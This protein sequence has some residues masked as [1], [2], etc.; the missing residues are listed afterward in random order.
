LELGSEFRLHLATAF[1]LTAAAPTKV[2][3]R[4][5][6]AINHTA[7]TM[8]S[9]AQQSTFCTT[10][11]PTCFCMPSRGPVPGNALSGLKLE[12]AFGDWH[13]GVCAASHAIGTYILRFTKLQI[14]SCTS[15]PQQRAFGL[16]THH[17]HHLSL[18]GLACGTGG[19][20]RHPIGFSR[21]ALRL[22]KLGYWEFTWRK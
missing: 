15:L 14:L 21:L 20:Q 10:A 9:A 3:M 19:S 18:L 12:D 22:R 5:N 17:W 4:P 13:R 16:A 8:G 6:R 2:C 1:G 11:M 7:K